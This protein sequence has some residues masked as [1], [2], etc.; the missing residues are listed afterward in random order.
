MRFLL[1]PDRKWIGIPGQSRKFFSPAKR[2][3]AIDDAVTLPATS[4]TVTI[5]VLDNDIAPQG[6]TLS[7]TQAYAALGT[8]SALPDGRVSYTPPG[9][10]GFDTIVYEITDDLGATDSGQVDVTLRAPEL[11]VDAVPGNRLEVAAETGPIDLTVDA[12]ASLAG[13]YGF[14]TADLSGGPV[15]LSPPGI[16]GVVAAGETLTAVPA[17][18]AAT[19]GGA[20]V[21]RQWRLAGADIAG[22]SAATYVVQPGDVGPGLDLVE[23]LSDA[24]GSRSAIS[25]T[26]G[27]AFTPA[28]DAA[29]IGWWDADEASTITA[30]AGA[31]QVWSDKSGGPASL[32]HGTA[33]RQPQTGTRLLAGRNVVDF[34]GTR[35]LEG[36]LDLPA[37]GDVA[38]HMAVI[39]D[40]IDNAYEAVLA[41]DAINDFQIDANDATSFAGRLN[42]AGS[43]SPLSLTGGPYSG[44]FI[45]SAVFDRT[46]TGQAEV[47]V[48]D[49]SRGQTAYVQ[50]LDASV[51]LTV[52]TNRS[53]N[54]WIDGAV[55]E[56]IVTGDV[57]NRADHHAYLA[58]KWGLT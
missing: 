53:K 13:A 50:P 44:A 57:T 35:F 18:W 16:D 15:V 43:G 55:A 12:P 30:N 21:T 27:L 1:D 52:M 42:I 34:D 31:V 20:V 49:V 10:E 17:L 40:A 4:G 8:A 56:L 36:N 6:R 37:S 2:P 19:P 11:S 58:A 48:S 29:V 41:V 38:F 47:F 23:T 33:F 45:L 54:A 32:G 22:A 26:V 7:L 24:G 5:A 46:G 25:A 9:I 3:V 28:A 14:D 51:A 39:V